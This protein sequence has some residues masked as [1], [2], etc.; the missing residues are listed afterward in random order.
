MRTI[1]SIAALVAIGPPRPR[2]L[3]PAAAAGAAIVL[4]YYGA[5]TVGY[6]I[7]PA[8]I[9]SLGLASEPLVVGL[10]NPRWLRSPRTIAT[11]TLAVAAMLLP[12]TATHA[13]SHH[14]LA[15]IGLVALGGACFVM[16]ARLLP[17]SATP[18]EA[19]R[20]TTFAQALGAVALIAVLAASGH[21]A[22]ATT[23][24][25]WLFVAALVLGSSLVGIALFVRAA[26][27]APAIA[28]SSLSLVPPL[29]A[30]LAWFALGDPM[31]WQLALSAIVAALAVHLST[32]TP[33]V[34]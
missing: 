26:Q 24:E 33:T 10:L 18:R 11:V 9:A 3:A 30:A 12:V 17:A 29:G 13:R 8:T 27:D 20:T 4:G 32:R 19:V 6:A 5:T 2:H 34:P 23:I 21:F 1:L 15:G 25:P 28:A 14:A 31:S 16:G 22:V 7:A